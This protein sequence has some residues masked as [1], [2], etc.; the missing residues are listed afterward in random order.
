MGLITL[1]VLAALV[2]F[3]VAIYNR[4]VRLRNGAESAW[5]DIDVQLK[6]RWEL[7]P[8]LVETVKGYAAHEQ[9]TFEAVTAARTAAMAA[10]TPG[11][12]S[13]AEGNLQNVLK[14]LFAVAEAYP[15]LK[16]NENFQQ[17]QGE[18]SGLEEV[19]QNARRYYNAIVR[20][21]NTACEVFPNNIVA[22]V[23]G[24]STMEYFELDSEA[25]RTAPLVDFG[26]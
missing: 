15:E 20:D 19:I 7:I 21:L 8:N 14:S 1:A 26:S 5:S 25:E 17:L 6:R 11:E 3:V 12:K 13:S 10:G 16:A 22:N 24:F 9:G 4:L 23:F 2:A 18:L